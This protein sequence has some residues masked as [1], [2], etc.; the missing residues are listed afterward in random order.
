VGWPKV[1]ATER[2]RLTLDRI[3]KLAPPAGSQAV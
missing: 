2:T 1:R 3:R